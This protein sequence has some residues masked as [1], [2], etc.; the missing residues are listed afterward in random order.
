MADGHYFEKRQMR[1][2]CSRLTDFDEIVYDDETMS[3]KGTCFRLPKMGGPPLSPRQVWWGWDF[4]RRGLCTPPGEQIKT[5]MFFVVFC[6]PRFW[7]ESL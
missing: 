2:L 1:Y 6:P 4:A 5:T 7:K 3:R